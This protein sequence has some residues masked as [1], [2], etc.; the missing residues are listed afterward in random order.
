[1]IWPVAWHHGP[2]VC[3]GTGE[4][5]LCRCQHAGRECYGSIGDD[6][7]VRDQKSAATGVEECLRRQTSG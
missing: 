2:Q 6:R 1:M 4:A 7:P 5:G 3:L